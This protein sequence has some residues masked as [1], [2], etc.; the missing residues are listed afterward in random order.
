MSVV[1][2]GA[3]IDGA[4]IPMSGCHIILK[5]RVNTSEVVMR[6]VADV[7]TG[8]C[9]EYCFKA[10]TGK[11]CVYLKQDWRDEYYVGDIA[12]YDDS[13]PGTL[14]DFLTALDEGDLKPDVVKRFEEMVVQAQQSA[15]IAASCAEQAGQILNNIQEVAG[16]LST[17]RFENFNDISRRCTT[18]MLKLE[19]PEVVNTSISLKIKEN[20]DFNYVGAVNGYCDIPEPEK[21]KVEMY[22]Y[23]TGEYFNGD[24]NLNS[25]GTFYFRR[26]WTGA[27][28]FRLIRIEDNAWITTLE[29][30]LLIRSYWMPEDAD[31][32]VIRVMKDRCYTYDQALAALALM[33]QRHEAVERYVSGLCALVDENGGVKFFV[34]RLS[35]MSSRAYYRLGNAAWVYYALAFYLEKYPDGAQVN[36]VRAKL[37]SG[38]SWLDSFLVTAPGDLRE[39]LYKGGLGRYVNGE[40]DAS[41]VAEW[42]ALEHNVDIWFL[43]ELMGRLEFDGFIQ[44]ADALAKSIIRGFWMEEEGRFRQG[45]H[46]TSYDNAAALDQ[47]SWGGLFVANIDMAKAVRCRKYMGRFFFG[48]REATGYTPYPPDYGYSGH[49]RGVWVEGT[50]GV[51]LFE[52]KLGNEVTAVNLIAAMAP[53]RDEYGYRDSCDD[54]AYDVLPPWPSTTNTA[55]VILTVKPD[56]FWLVD[57]PIMDVGMIRY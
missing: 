33:V 4:G 32:D 31:P 51:A 53:L 27:K 43:F 56:N 15:E 50:A 21:Y 54:P 14:N 6:T 38:I 44:R 41:F 20:I 22:A 40:F 57:S 36:I 39:G 30:P 29:F 24:A 46:P 37:L 13:K 1:I 17:V 42:C 25:D 35:A 28:Q 52:R 12:V 9:G 18:A 3:L 47:S 8:N 45:V 26:C 55:W 16:Q 5:S 2:S 11:Y 34:N 23:T 7:V 49:S 10:Q 48:T 19:Q